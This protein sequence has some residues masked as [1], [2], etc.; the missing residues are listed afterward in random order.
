[1]EAKLQCSYCFGELPPR[2]DDLR[3]PL[4]ELLDEPPRYCS[5]GC[6]RCGEERAKQIELALPDAN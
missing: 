1:M 6:R 4:Q 2:E 5:D 3:K